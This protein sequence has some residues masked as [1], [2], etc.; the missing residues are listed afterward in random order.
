MEGQHE[1]PGRKP[2]LCSE[3]YRLNQDPPKTNQRGPNGSQTWYINTLTKAK[4]CGTVFL[5][6]ERRCHVAVMC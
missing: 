5:P 2:K 3:R 1:R 6:G 4:I